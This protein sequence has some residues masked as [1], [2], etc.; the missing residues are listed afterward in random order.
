MRTVINIPAES[1]P[2]YV[3]HALEGLARIATEQISTGAFPLL[4]RSGV[5]Y[6][7]ERGTENWQTPA[8]V[9]ETG[10]ADC[11]D[12]SAYR[13]GELRASGVDPGARVVIVRTGPRTLHAVVRR[14]DGS[15]EDPSRALGMRGPGDGVALPSMLVGVEPSHTWYEAKRR[16]PR[17][18]LVSA[19]TL[20]EALSGYTM[21]ADEGVGFIPGLDIVSRAAQG[22]LSAVVPGMSP[23]SRG[24]VDPAA[25]RAQAQAIARQM[26]SARAPVGPTASPVSASDVL[27]IASQLARVVHAEKLRD[28][29]EQASRRRSGGSW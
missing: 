28:R 16:A 19:P 13:V 7:R 8:E 14:S 20:A 21:G 2:R 27:S 29:R 24:A 10:R 25:A 4:Y 18:D 17:G 26:A 3:E 5:R 6:E 23:S 15:T 1:A 11:E 22:A 12:L 9:I